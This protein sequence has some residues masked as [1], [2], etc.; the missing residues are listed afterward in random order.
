MDIRVCS[1]SELGMRE[2]I[3]AA[4]SRL[5]LDDKRLEASSTLL[6]ADSPHP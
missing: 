4:W 6:P 5:D 3:E 1:G 2:N